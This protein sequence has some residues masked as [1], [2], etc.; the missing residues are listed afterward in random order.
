VTGA[1]YLFLNKAPFSRAQKTLFIFGYFPLYEYSVINRSYG[2]SMLLLFLTCSLYKERF[3]KPLIFAVALFFLTNTHAFSGLIAA[4]IFLSM[5][6]E[7]AVYREALNQAGCAKGRRLIG[8]AC[9][10]LAGIFLCAICALPDITSRIFNPYSLHLSDLPRA[11]LAA[12]VHPGLSFK[13]AFPGISPIYISLLIWFLFI[14]FLL[15]RPP[16]FIIFFASIVGLAV[17]FQMVPAINDARHHGFAYLML[18]AAFWIDVSSKGQLSIK[19]LKTPIH[20]VSRYMYIV[21]YLLLITQ[22]SP[23]SASIKR[24]IVSEFSSSKTLGQYLK[25]NPEL[26]DAILIGEPDY[27]LIP[28]TYYVD[29]PIFVP[30]EGKFRSF[31]RFPPANKKDFTLKELLETAKYLKQTHGKPV[32][33]V[34]GLR[35]TDKNANSP[36]WSGYG[37]TFTYDH[38][39]KEMLLEQT[40]RLKRFRNAYGCDEN[41]DLYL[42]KYRPVRLLTDGRAR[43]RSRR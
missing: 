7:F 8:A 43:L 23:A 32:L 34:L 6:M 21:I 4:A 10:V 2:L 11:L 5:A 33:I 20:V 25:Q 27:T 22:L 41:Y 26:N 40:I 9:V 18:V 1:I 14:Y 38:E 39:S 13:H 28:V 36:I 12:L 31:V 3:R 35:L 37:R 24:D 16:T 19:S 15:R 29:N 17:F 42:V 30:R